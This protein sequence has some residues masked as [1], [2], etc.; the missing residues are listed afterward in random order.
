MI[1]RSIGIGAPR[2]FITLHL[3]MT[4]SV[5]CPA[6]SA[7]ETSSTLTEI[8]LPM[9]RFSSAACASLVVTS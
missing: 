1:D 8:S 3:V 4:A 7:Q 5:I 6:F 2:Y 9:K